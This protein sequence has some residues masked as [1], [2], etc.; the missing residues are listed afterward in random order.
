MSENVRSHPEGCRCAGLD[1]P[2][3]VQ[4]RRSAVEEEYSALTASLAGT[5][6]AHQVLDA[7][8]V[9]KRFETAN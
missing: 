8:E 3:P 4:Y 2:C 6:P 7:R 1:N 9:L 5:A